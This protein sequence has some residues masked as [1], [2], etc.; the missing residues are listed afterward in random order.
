MRFGNMIFTPPQ[1]YKLYTQRPQ[2]YAV[3][4]FCQEFMRKIDI[5][6]IPSY[7][8]GEVISMT[9]GERIRTI[10]KEKGMTQK[11][12]A[13]KLGITIGAYSHYETGKRAIDVITVKKLSAIFGV[14]GDELIDTGFQNQQPTNIIQM[15][16]LQIKKVPLLGTMAA[17]E[18]VYDEEF[19]GI[20]ADSPQDCDF[21][22]RVV[23]DS[24]EPTYLP[25]DIVFIK[26]HPD[27]PYNGAIVVLSIDN[28]ACIKHVSVVPSGIM[29]SSDNPTYPARFLPAAEHKFKILGVPVGFTRMYTKNRP[30]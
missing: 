6:Y 12:V 15:S 29:I 23:G 17:G 11:E 5:L 2:L 25:G 30:R 18:P 24:M 3:Y 9:E 10:R 27:L 21:A 28:E 26:Q 20:Y 14:S 13:E 19:P 7:N 22:L 8:S 1:L 4:T 16:E